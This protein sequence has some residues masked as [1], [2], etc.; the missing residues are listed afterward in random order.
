[1]VPAA[2]SRFLSSLAVATLGAVGLACNDSLLGP[3]TLENFVD[4]VTLHALSGTAI[5]LPSGFSMIDAQPVRTDSTDFD[6]AFEITGSGAPLIYPS[7]ALGLSTV[8]GVQRST[9]AFQD[10]KMAPI[11]GYESDSAL[12]VTANDVFLARSR[13]SFVGCLFFGQVS[14]YGKFRVLTIDLSARSITLEMLVNRNCGYRSLEVGL[15]DS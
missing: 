15:P 6:F 7:G 8:P 10:I 2:G 1:M 5:S 14:R 13:T 9:K 3:A 4:T 11:D 12:A